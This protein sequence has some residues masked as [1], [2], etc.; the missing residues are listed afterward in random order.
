MNSTASRFSEPST[1]A[2]AKK[3]EHYQTNTPIHFVHHLYFFG[4][5]AQNRNNLVTDLVKLMNIVFN[6]YVKPKI[7]YKII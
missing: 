6:W 1:E 4:F 7:T 3:H 5:K 2:N